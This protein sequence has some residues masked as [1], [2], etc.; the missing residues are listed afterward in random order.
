MLRR[1]PVR[2]SWI[3]VLSAVVGASGAL[4]AASWVDSG[5]GAGATEIQSAETGTDVPAVV[6]TRP[7]PLSC[8]PSPPVVA[9]LVSGGDAAAWR[10]RLEA[11]ATVS[12]VELSMGARSGGQDLVPVVVWRGELAQG[13]TRDVD[14]RYAPPSGATEVW[15][16]A[17]IEVPGAVQRSRA[18]LALQDGRAM[19]VAAAPAAAHRLL[20]DPVSGLEVL[21]VVGTPG[22]SR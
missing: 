15:V 16:D 5:I 19:P 6:S 21:E 17:S 14:V 3:L 7:H 10:V 8:K 12:Q 13:E 18:A 22:G 11:L 2:V 1:I 9:T 20:H 4:L